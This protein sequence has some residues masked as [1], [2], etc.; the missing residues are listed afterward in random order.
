M[1]PYNQYIYFTTFSPFFFLLFHYLFI[2][3]FYR[4]RHLGKRNHV[5]GNKLRGDIAYNYFEIMSVK[6]SWL[7]SIKLQIQACVNAFQLVL[8][9]PMFKCN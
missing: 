3:F 9:T 2:Y 1:K 7:A 6:S 5:G 4:F 8:F